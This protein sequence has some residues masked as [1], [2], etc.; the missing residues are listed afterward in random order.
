[1]YSYSLLSIHYE[2]LITLETERDTKLLFGVVNFSR[3][4]KL[5][6]EQLL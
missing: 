6:E 2:Y 3:N 4:L 1:M 5:I